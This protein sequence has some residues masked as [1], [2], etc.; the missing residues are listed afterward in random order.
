M[1]TMATGIVWELCSQSHSFSA[2]GRLLPIPCQA[3]NTW[4]GSTGA[5]SASTS[6]STTRNNSRR[7]AFSLK[8]C[9]LAASRRL[10]LS[11][12]ARG[13]GGLGRLTL[14]SLEVLMIETPLKGHVVD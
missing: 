10:G 4:F 13:G 2:I 12:H 8:E 1:K 14:N 7:R 5:I 11:S 6:T 9:P 3:A